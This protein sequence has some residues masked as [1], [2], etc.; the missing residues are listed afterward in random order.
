MALH[1]DYFYGG[2]A[3]QFS[4]YRIPKVLFK[5]K[6]YKS[7]SVE[8]KALYGLMLDRMSLSLRSGWLDDVQR[9]YIYFTLEDAL[10]MMGIGK[11]KAVKLFKELDAIGLIERKKQGQGRPT[12]IYV[13]NFVLPKDPDMPDVSVPVT[14]PTPEASQKSETSECPKSALLDSLGVKTSEKPKSRLL[15]GRSPDFGKTDWNYTEKKDTEISDTDPSIYPTI[16]ARQTESSRRPVT[17]RDEMDRMD[18]YKEQI[19]EN[20]QY[21]Y[22]MQARSGDADIIDGYVELMV[23]VCC[24]RKDFIRI[25]GEE[26]PLGVVKS[27][28]FKLTH[29]HILYV[30]DSMNSNTTLIGNIKAYTLAALYNAPATIS[31]YYMSLVSHDMACGFAEE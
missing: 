25:C 27:R 14:H 9:V 15:K 18:L 12:R 4:F 5:D 26:V 7:V 19:K 30:L 3:E 17:I 8:A 23:E 13:K 10:D 21:D 20:I 28:F 2:E 6:R 29:E 24:S 11:D 31:Q 1:L 22:L 16:P